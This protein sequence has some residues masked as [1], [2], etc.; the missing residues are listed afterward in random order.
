MKGGVVVVDG[1]VVC[2][3]VVGGDRQTLS[4]L[5]RSWGQW[6]PK[7]RRERTWVA[8]SPWHPSHSLQDV[9]EESGAVVVEGPLL[10]S[11][12]SETEVMRRKGVEE[13]QST[14]ASQSTHSTP[15]PTQAEPQMSSTYLG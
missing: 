8:W 4:C 10:L 15:V 7:Q 11:R 5:S 13:M 12:V 2:G 1:V 9:Q 3:V 14:G 6:R